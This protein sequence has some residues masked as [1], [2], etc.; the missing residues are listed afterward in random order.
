[1]TARPPLRPYALISVPGFFLSY[2]VI[3]WVVNTFGVPVIGLKTF[4]MEHATP[5]FQAMDRVW[6]LVIPSLMSALG[7]MAI[8]SRYVRSQM[9]EVIGHD[10]I[11]TA[12]AKGAEED[13]V[14]Y[15]H[16]AAKRPAAFCDHVWIFAPRPDWRLR[17]FLNRFSRGPGWAGWATKPFWQE[18]SRSF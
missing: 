1:M 2:L 9:L 14:I 5:L 3:L 4:G 6:H 13:A 11:R 15:R 7:G 18:I 16:C 10:Y 8:L 17:S 12:R